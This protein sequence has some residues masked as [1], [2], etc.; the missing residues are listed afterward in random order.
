MSKV[1]ASLFDYPETFTRIRERSHHSGDSQVVGGESD[2]VAAKLTCILKH[3]VVLVGPH[4][5]P[6]VV[7]LVR[8]LG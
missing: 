7:W 4:N 6:K 3:D 2:R 8:I 1:S 5:S